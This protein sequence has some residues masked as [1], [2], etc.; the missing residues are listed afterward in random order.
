MTQ[1][2]KTSEAVLSI[3]LQYRSRS[4]DPP[5]QGFGRGSDTRRG[6]PQSRVPSP[7]TMIKPAPG[8]P[9]RTGGLPARSTDTSMQQAETGNGAYSIAVIAGDGIGK[10]VIPA[11]IAAIEA[12]IRGSGVTLTFTE[13]PWGCEYYG[14]HGRMMDAD[15][16]ERLAR[17]DAIYLGA[18]GSPTRA[19]SH[20]R[21]GSAAAAAPALP[22]IRQPAADA[23]AAR[24]DLAA[25][26][27]RTG[28][29]RHGVR[30][31]E[32]RGRIRRSRR[33][34]SRRHAA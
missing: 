30:A 12:A 21:L 31:R 29:Y 27:S 16:F 3:R 32:L 13:L 10:E 20:C 2:N 23:S 26:Q 17:F 4:E 33:P 25:R 6:S 14:R 11:G 24:P 7:Q 34:H 5:R 8:G 28:G 19:R 9:S 15:G 18:I 1:V 22:A